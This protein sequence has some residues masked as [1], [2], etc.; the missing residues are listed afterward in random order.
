VRF[1]CRPADASFFDDAPMRFK[2]E[3]ELSA[4][5]AAVFAILEDAST[6]PRW[7][8]GMRDAVWTSAK[9]GGVGSTRRVSLAMLTLDER[10]YHW[11]PGRRLSFYLTSQSMPL[12]HSLAEDYLLEELTPMTTRF[13][14]SV[15]LEP[16][17]A[18][19]MA[20][21]VARAYFGSMFR[22]ACEG[23]AR[24]V[25]VVALAPGVSNARS[26]TQ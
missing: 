4:G 10:F 5:P 16:R 25:Q 11:E 1:P 23:L 20:G 22:K 8:S 3:V 19:A 18:V 21:P 7:F 26:L 9:A 2:N 24:Y 12:A 14:Y 6:W 17:L 13:T 15:A